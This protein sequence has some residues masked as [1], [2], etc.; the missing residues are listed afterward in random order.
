MPLVNQLRTLSVSKLITLVTILVALLPISILSYHMYHSTWD[1]SWR[2]IHEKHQ[3]LA[4]NLAIPLGIYV[5]DHRVMLLMIGETISL[6]AQQ[7]NARTTQLL[8]QSVAQSRGFN[9]LIVLVKT[10]K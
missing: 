8:Q 7:D 5:D 10:S 4:Q 6:L 3:L 1:N 2:E 9:S